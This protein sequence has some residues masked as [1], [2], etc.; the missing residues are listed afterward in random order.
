[1]IKAIIFD[2]G[3]VICYPITKRLVIR[4]KEQFNADERAIRK[5]YF[6]DLHG[7]EIGKLSD[8]EFWQNFCRELNIKVDENLVMDIVRNVEQLDK[9]VYELLVQLKKTKR[10]KLVLLSNNIPVMVNYIRKKFD[11]SVFDNLFFSNEIGMRKP[12]LDIF[13]HVLKEINSNKEDKTI[14]KIL[15]E[16]TIFIDDKQENLDT[17]AQLKI[18]TILFQ[19]AEQLKKDLIVLE[20]KI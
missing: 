5:A 13:E 17:A 15:P 8:K 16:E 20:V 10:Y 3:G 9:E 7:Y 19:N 6:K 12:H 4:L 11:L 18:K 14:T 2:W 1:M